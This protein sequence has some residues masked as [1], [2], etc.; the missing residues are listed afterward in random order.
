MKI[1][2]FLPFFC[3]IFANVIF[4][5]S[6]LFSKTALSTGVHPTVILA[7][8]FFVSFLVIN[9]LVLFGAVK[10]SFKNKPVIKIL[11]MAVFQPVLYFIFELYGVKEVS[12]AVSGVI[13]ALVP[14]LVCAASGVF[15]KEKPTT[16]QIV[17]TVISFLCVAGISIISKQGS[18]FSLLGLLL[19]ILAV[20]CAAAFNV[21][22][23][24][25]ASV[26]SA[27][28]RTYIMFAA[29]FVVFSV[30]PFFT[31]GQNYFGELAKAAVNPS[32]II[33]IIYLSVLSSVCAF[34]M[35]NYCTGKIG[36]V[37]AS[38][39]SNIITVISVPAGIIFLKE[40]VSF[41]VL[42]LC[43]VIMFCVYMVNKQGVKKVCKQK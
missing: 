23:R 32:I 41:P 19:L 29:A 25:T 8:R 42:A 43:I 34:L 16:L 35:Y 37:K 15:L 27:A 22:S 26:F 20:V 24:S 38:S 9:L 11:L 28:E 33:S 1:K 31:V 4:G 10:V 3:G 2:N 39:Y 7:I 40:E 6:F 17:F 12:T 13:L 5:F 21:L 30:L 14:V 36:V 18:G